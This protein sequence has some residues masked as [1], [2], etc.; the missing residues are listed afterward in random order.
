MKRLPTMPSSPLQAEI[1]K[2]WVIVRTSSLGPKEESFRLGNP[3]II[4]AGIPVMHDP[5]L[6]E[7]P[8]FVA[9][10]AIPL[11]VVVVILV[12]EAA[13]ACR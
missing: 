4:D 3:N 2:S 1:A 6:I 11:T 13:S 8:V 7:L 10:G 9:V 5:F 12:S